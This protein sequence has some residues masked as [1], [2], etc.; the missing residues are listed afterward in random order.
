MPLPK[1][2]YKQL[3]RELRKY[4]FVSYGEFL[5]SEL[6]AGFRK[7]ML[8]KKPPE[9]CFLCKKHATNYNLHHR[10]YKRIIDPG[11]VCW[12]CEPCH[13][14]IHERA[15]KSI[16]QA[17]SEM[18]RKTVKTPKIGKKEKQKAAVVF[19]KKE[20]RILN[21]RL[22]PSSNLPE[23]LH[24]SLHASSCVI[25]VRQGQPVNE[26]MNRY[27]DTKFKRNDTAMYELFILNRPKVKRFL[28]SFK[29]K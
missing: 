6:W 26:V 9:C 22:V 17:T 24:H 3:V 25:S 8:T 13:L 28:S 10:S 5:G 11:L 7:Q 1:K 4:G 21:T 23:A 27:H 16:E 15:G 20:K 29:T 2:N 14:A 12:V 18:I 19:T